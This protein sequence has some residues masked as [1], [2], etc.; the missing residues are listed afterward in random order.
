MEAERG[1]GQGN[2]QVCHENRETESANPI[3]IPHNIT[4][5]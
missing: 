2:D 3:I 1:S 4:I 5:P